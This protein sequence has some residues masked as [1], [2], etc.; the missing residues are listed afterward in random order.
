[1]KKLTLE[2]WD[3]IIEAFYR[4]SLNH[5]GMVG[6]ATKDEVEKYLG[7]YGVHNSL[8]WSEQDGE[9]RG[10][11]TAHPGKRN[12]DWNWSEEN[13]IWTAHVVWADNVQAHA[14]V[15]RQFLETKHPVKALY[16]WR[17]K[18]AVPLTFR[19]LERI[20]SYGRRR[21][22]NSSTSGSELRTVNAGDPASAS[23]SGAA[24]VREG[25]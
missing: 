19:K 24:G 25:S 12:F 21:H 20:L 3:K 14:E 5:L 22:N 13:G 15:L 9:I 4:K 16:T 10:V 17:K 7:F 8:Y 23:R 2:L 6:H 18:Q 11:S 1:M